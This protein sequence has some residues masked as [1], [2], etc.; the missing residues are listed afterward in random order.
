MTSAIR[1]VVTDAPALVTGV[2]VAVLLLLTAF[3]VPLTDEQGK[4]IVALVGAILTLGGAL[5]THAATTPNA[6]VD[7]IV[8][9]LQ[10][11]G[12]IAPSEASTPPA[13]EASQG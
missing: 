4:A 6:H 12:A 10:A 1:G 9:T 5:Y 2:V 13:V 3:G 7:T 8:R 11:P